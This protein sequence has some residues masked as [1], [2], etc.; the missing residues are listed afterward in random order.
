MKTSVDKTLFSRISI[1]HEPRDLLGRALL[2]AE[3]AARQ[4]GVSLSFASMHELV[5]VHADNR[6]TWGALYTGFVPEFNDLTQDNSFC[7]LGRNAAGRVVATQVARVYDWPDSSFHEETQNL[8]IFYRDPLAQKLPGERCEVT[9]LAAKGV[10]GRVLYSGGAWYHPDY[11]G[12]GLVEILPRLARALAHARWNT[13][14]TITLMAEHNIKKG[15]FP[16]NG[17]RNIEWDVRFVGTRC[18]DIRFALLWLKRN[19]ML[20]DLEH[21]LRSFEVELGDRKR[22]AH[23]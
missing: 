16:R 8:R 4:R 23:A 18:G 13:D 22:A 3:A 10:R 5:S 9:A 2:K 17:Y 20:E 1:N 6:A 12:L 15:V 7:L 19:E 21:F 11:R 14:C